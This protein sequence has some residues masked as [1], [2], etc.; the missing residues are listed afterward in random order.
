[1]S[2]NTTRSRWSPRL[3][4]IAVATTPAAGEPLSVVK[5]DSA[6]V[7]IAQPSR[8]VSVRGNAPLRTREKHGLLCGGRDPLKSHLPYAAPNAKYGAGSKEREDM[9]GLTTRTK[10]RNALSDLDLYVYLLSGWRWLQLASSLL[11]SSYKEGRHSFP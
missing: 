10:G 1:M 5:T 3:T 9:R 11:Q 2:I 8:A 4:R 7:H 6:S